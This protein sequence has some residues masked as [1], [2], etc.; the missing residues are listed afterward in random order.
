MQEH[1]TMA[2]EINLHEVFRRT[3]NASYGWEKD[4]DREQE[5]DSEWVCMCILIMVVSCKSFSVIAHS[6]TFSRLFTFHFKVFGNSLLL[7]LNAQ[8]HTVICSHLMWSKILCL[9]ELCNIS[10]LCQKSI[11]WCKFRMC[12]CKYGP[13]SNRSTSCCFSSS[14]LTLFYYHF[15]VIYT[16]ALC[17]SSDLMKWIFGVSRE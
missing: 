8:T 15:V 1:F 9:L 16:G 11:L 12:A 5:W 3:R 14:I 6:N 2:N 7:Y 17:P 13:V 10:A 4:S